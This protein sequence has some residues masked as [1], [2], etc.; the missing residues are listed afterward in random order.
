MYESKHINI[1]SLFAHKIKHTRFLWLHFAILKPHDLTL[2]LDINL[3][4]YVWAEAC[5][6]ASMKDPLC[7]SDS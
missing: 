6:K 5:K 7:S 3:H 4:Q 2:L 1:G